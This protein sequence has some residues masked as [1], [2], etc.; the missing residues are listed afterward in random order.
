MPDSSKIMAVTKLDAAQRQLRTG[1]RL[2]FY[3]GDPVSIHTLLAASHEIIHRLYRRKGLVNLLFDSDHFNDEYRGSFAKRM[4]E[5]PNF[6]KHANNDDEL[7]KSFS[8][9]PGLND[10]LP[11][12]LVQALNDMGEE[13]GLEEVSYI[14]WMKLYEPNAFELKVDIFPVDVTKKLLGVD[15]KDFFD[16]CEL[17]WGQGR[18]RNFLRPRPPEQKGR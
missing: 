11:L 4:K 15:K 6:F 2:W 17:L 5:A 18:M 8:F 7:D 16:A 3:D 1:L 10:I 12:F 13:L 9:N 14:Y